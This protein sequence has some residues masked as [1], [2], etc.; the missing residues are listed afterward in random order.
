MRIALFISI[1]SGLIFFSFLIFVVKCDFDSFVIN[2]SVLIIDS[3]EPSCLEIVKISDKEWPFF[4]INNKCQVPFKINGAEYT[5]DISSEEILLMALSDEKYNMF[6]G[7]LFN[8]K[9]WEI[10]GLIGDKSLIIRGKTQGDLIY[11]TVLIIGFV[12]IIFFVTFTILLLFERF[13]KRAK[14]RMN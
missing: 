4:N 2:H 7:G 11:F 10:N 9:R 1:F 12:F 8:S 3:I 6:S 5:N 14:G 13:F